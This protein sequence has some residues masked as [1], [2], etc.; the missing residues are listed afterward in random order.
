MPS[1]YQSL[2]YLD[3]QTIVGEVHVWWK[4]FGCFSMKADVVTGVDKVGL[5]GM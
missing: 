1:I 2:L 3:R 5:L 4:D